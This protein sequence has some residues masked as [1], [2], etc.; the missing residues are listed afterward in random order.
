MILVL[1]RWVT[2][3]LS[4]NLIDPPLAEWLDLP[5]SVGND[6]T[7]IERTGHPPSLCRPKG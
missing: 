5:L 7:A 3:P 6:K 1:V 2:L 4:T